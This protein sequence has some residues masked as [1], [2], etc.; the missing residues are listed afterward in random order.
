MK[1]ILIIE[2]D[3]ALAHALSEKLTGGGFEVSISLDGESGL[4]NL[5]NSRPGLV[6]LDLILPR[7]SGFE[8]L[9][10]VRESADFK[11]LPVLVLTN[12][13]SPYD[14]Q[15]VF[16]LGISGYLVKANYSLDD[17]AKKVE[18]ILA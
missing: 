2:D 6:L 12:L 13:E 15:R 8:V 18:Q 1:K 5:E 14:I 3:A 9:K 7:K 11:N 16:E 17:I 4:K 10:A